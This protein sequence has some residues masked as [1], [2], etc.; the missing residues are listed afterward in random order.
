MVTIAG[1]FK[2][3]PSTAFA[4]ADQEQG[5]KDQK[6]YATPDRATD[7]VLPVVRQTRSTPNVSFFCQGRL[8]VKLTTTLPPA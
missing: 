7:D 5:E 8:P 6:Q 4:T 3:P 1:V 2:I